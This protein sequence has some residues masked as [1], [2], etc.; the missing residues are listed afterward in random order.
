MWLASLVTQFFDSGVNP[1]KTLK[2]NW[3][4]PVADLFR[5]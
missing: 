4:T 1:W 2:A 5:R 3:L